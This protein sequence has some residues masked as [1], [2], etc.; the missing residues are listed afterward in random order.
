[1]L[2]KIGKNYLR[3]GSDG[4][5]APPHPE[6]QGCILH[7]EG[8]N[9][10]VVSGLHFLFFLQQGNRMPPLPLLDALPLLAARSFLCVYVMSPL[11]WQVNCSPFLHLEACGLPLTTATRILFV[12]F[13]ARQQT[14]Q[15]P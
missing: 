4:S 5:I 10:P 6:E 15:L 14:P 9:Q 7:F 8:E 1:M 12:V 3:G 2:Q 13:A 11:P